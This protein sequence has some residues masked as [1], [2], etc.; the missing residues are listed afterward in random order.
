MFPYTKIGINAVS[1]LLSIT[2]LLGVYK[3]SFVLQPNKLNQSVNQPIV[4]NAIKEK[5]N[6]EK[7][8]Q[9]NT[10][11]IKEKITNQQTKG[12]TLTNTNT[13]NNVKKVS[14]KKLEDIWEI[15]IPKIQLKAKIAEGTSQ[16]VMKQFV[17]H[18]EDTSFWNGNVG[19]A[20]HNRGYPVN[21]FQN[22]KKLVVGD[23]IFYRT[24]LGTR[25]YI[26]KK[27]TVITDVDWSYLEQTKENTLT[28]LTCVENQPEYRRCVQAIEK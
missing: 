19:L 13:S 17:G 5:N 7:E 9:K 23:T 18:F 2:I 3:A 15:E 21:Y 22:L 28:L 11:T 20:A 27:V 26:V 25:E 8:E 10:N 14:P 12:N 1:F 6:T 24:K 4:E 16:E